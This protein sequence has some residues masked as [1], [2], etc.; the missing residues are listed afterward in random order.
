MA[1]SQW[2]DG[3][4]VCKPDAGE[5]ASERSVRIFPLLSQPPTRS[6]RLDRARDSC[7]FGQTTGEDREVD[8]D[9]ARCCRRG[10]DF[11]GR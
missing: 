8:D 3:R 10:K 4:L 2:L 11:D 6:L 7:Q 9:C 1:V 5:V